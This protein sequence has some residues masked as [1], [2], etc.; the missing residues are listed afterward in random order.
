MRTD[1]DEEKRGNMLVLVLMLN[2]TTGT[3]LGSIVY[4]V[5]PEMPSPSQK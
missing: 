4:F 3:F 5:A 1:C 2:A